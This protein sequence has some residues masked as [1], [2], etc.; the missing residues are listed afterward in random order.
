MNNGLSVVCSKNLVT[1]I[2]CGAD[3]THTKIN[4]PFLAAKSHDLDRPFVYQS[5]VMPDHNMD[6]WIEDN[7]YSKS[8]LVR[9]VWLF[10]KLFK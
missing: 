10:N 8:L 1:N 2:G 4:N 5:T 7:F 9:L 3:A 6:K